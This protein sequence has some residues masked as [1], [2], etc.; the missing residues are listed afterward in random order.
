M[1]KI[2]TPFNRRS[3]RLIFTS[4]ES[5]EL[6]KYAANS[7]LALKI[8]FMNEMALI[9]EKTDAN[10]HEIRKGIGSDPR[11]GSAFLYAGLGYGGSCFPKDVEALMQ[12]QKKLGLNNKL[13]RQAQDI[14]EKQIKLFT[15]K[16]IQGIKVKDK[17]EIIL[18]VWGLSFKP[19]TDDIRE[20]M[21]LKL[22]KNLSP[23]VKRINLYDP[24]ANENARRELR[25]LT[26]LKFFTNKYRAL[27]NADSLIVA[28]EWKEFWDPDL[29]KLKRLKSK[30][31][32]D[33][34]NILNQDALIDSGLKYI[35]IGI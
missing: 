19:N 11:I 13:L 21:S 7:F 28:T 26:N 15:K 8:S 30:V 18:T 23:L 24:L 9:C 2:Y 34:R 32:F 29:N 1:K 6:I 16:I 27:S 10:I 20:S 35:G 5:A 4:T 12:T 25:G 14:N 17:K 22:I 33:G 31:I 3:D